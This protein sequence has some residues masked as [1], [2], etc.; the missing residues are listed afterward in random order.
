M[1]IYTYL[2]R[3][4]IDTGQLIMRYLARCERS[5]KVKTL[6]FLAAEVFS[7]PGRNLPDTSLLLTLILSTPL[8]VIEQI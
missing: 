8:F 6:M 7:E 1:C 4:S 3:L 2:H 5:F